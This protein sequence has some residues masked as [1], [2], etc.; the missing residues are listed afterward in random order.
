FFD[1]FFVCYDAIVSSTQYSIN[2]LEQERMGEGYGFAARTRCH[3]RSPARGSG[4]GSQDLHCN[5][6]YHTG[7][8]SQLIGK[9]VMFVYPWRM[10]LSCAIFC[11]VSS[12]MR[13]RAITC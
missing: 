3:G 4:I 6:D 13:A 7:G 2:A 9:L 8:Y 5:E 11:S 10:V 1:E 12:V